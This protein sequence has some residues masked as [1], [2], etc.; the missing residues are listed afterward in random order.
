MNEPLWL[1]RD[2]CLGIHE[3]M[4]S[5]HGGLSGVRDEGLL[6]SAIAKPQNHFA[7]GSR[8]LTEMAAA[9]AA[10]I[11]LN[12]PFLDGNK[13]TGFMVAVTFLELNGLELTA[14]EEAAVQNTVDLASGQVSETHYAGW[15]EANCKTNE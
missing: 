7:Y 2:D 13:R 10:G 5:Q 15:L 12:H 9:Y 6:L 8:S 11:V 3:M 14:S 1:D 4:L